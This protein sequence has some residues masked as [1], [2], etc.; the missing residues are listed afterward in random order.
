MNGALAPENKMAWVELPFHHPQAAEAAS[1]QY[2]W[3]VSWSA[4][5]SAK[6]SISR[7]L[8]A[9]RAKETIT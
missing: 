8:A 2:L 7:E 6:I 5:L 3:I 1:L 9:P 4:L